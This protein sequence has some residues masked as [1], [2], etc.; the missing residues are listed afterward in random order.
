MSK[1]VLSL[2][3]ALV[4]CL[5]LLP[6]AI[7]EEA[8]NGGIPAVQSGET[9]VAEAGGTKYET[10]QEAFD[11]FEE[12][13][14]LLCSVEED[15]DVSFPA[16]VDMNGFSITG[17]VNVDG[18]LTLINGTVIGK[19]TTDTT[20][21]VMTAPDGAEAAIN[22]GLEVKS[23]GCLI[24][25]AK[26][27]VIKT[28]YVD[29]SDDVII[30]G[31][32]KAVS[33]DA[34]A[35]PSG[36][37]LY[38][39][40]TENGDTSLEAVFESD[41][42]KVGGEVA[43]KLSN[44]QVG[45]STPDPV[46][47]V[48]TIMPDSKEIYA[49]QTAE[50][51]VTYDGTDTLNAYV[52]NNAIDGTIVETLTKA[53]AANEWKF[54]VKTTE[55]AKAGT[56]R[57]Y[58]RTINNNAINA[59]AKLTINSAVAKD[60]EG[61]YYGDIK[62]AVEQAPD[63][64]TVTV[65]AK[66]NQLSLPDEIYV[67]TGSDGITLDLNGHS[68]GGYPLNVG[69]LT[70]TSKLRTGKLTV[71]DSSGGNGAVGIAVRDGG[72]FIFNPDNLS[73]NLLQLQVYGGNI[74]L[75]GGKISRD[76]LHLYKGNTLSK[77]L[78]SGK[79]L[80]YRRADADYWI[81]L[82]YTQNKDYQPSFDLVV[83]KCEHT[84]IDA[85]NNCLYCGQSLAAKSGSKYYMTLEAAVNAANKND[86]VTL[87]KSVDENLYIEKDITINLG[88]NNYTIMGNVTVRNGNTLTLAGG[89]IVN[90]VQSGTRYDGVVGG[91]LNILSDNVTVS[92]L[93]VQQI[94]NPP[95]QLNKGTF[96]KIE[97]T[98]NLE[99]KMSA[100]GLLAE[101]YAFALPDGT[102]KDGR[103]NPLISVKI[104]EHTHDMTRGECPCGFTCAHS[105]GYTN[106]E[107][108]KC[109]AKCPHTNV[110]ETTY[111]CGTCDMQMVVKIEKNGAISYGTNLSDVM[112]A[113]EGGETFT[114]LENTALNG[115]IIIA[116]NNKTVILD[117][118][119]YSV[120]ENGYGTF[121]VGG[122]TS[123]DMGRTG[124]LIIKGKGN[125]K[126]GLNI[127]SSGELDLSGWTGEEIGALSVYETA[128]VTG[129]SG[130]AHINSFWLN[131][132][133]TTDIQ[134]ILLSGGSYGKIIW[135]NYSGIDLTLGSLL[136]SGYAFQKQ[137]DGTFVS[138]SDK[139]SPDSTT[140]ISNVKVVKCNGNTDSDGDGKCDNCNRQFVAM[141]CIEHDDDGE[142][143][144][145]GF[146]DLQDAIDL[147]RDRS[148]AIIL[149][150]NVNGNYTITNDASIQMRSYSIDGTVTVSGNGIAGFYGTGEGRVNN[151]I[152]S[153]PNAKFNNGDTAVIKRLTIENGATWKTIL[154]DRFGYKKMFNATSYKW[155]DQDTITDYVGDNQSI[156]L[157][158]IARL[159]V[160]SNPTLK[161]DNARLPSNGKK[162]V[163][164]YEPLKFGVSVNGGKEYIICIQKQ[165]E[166]AITRLEAKNRPYP[167]Q[168]TYH[169][170]DAFEF[171]E[172]GTYEVWTEVSKDGYTR[173]S[174]KYTF[175]VEA[176]L[177]AA[178]VELEQS[179]FTYSGQVCTPKIKSVKIFGHDVPDTA[180]TV[181][182]SSD[183]TGTNASDN[184]S[185]RIVAAN[186]GGYTGSAI[187]KWKILPRVLTRVVACDYIK[188]YDGTTNV[189][190]D[191]I[192][193]N[194]L[195]PYFYYEGGNS[196]R[197]VLEYGTDYS[198]TDLDAKFLTPDA[199]S[200]SDVTFTVTLKN[201]NYTFKDENE[202]NTKTKTVTQGMNI[203]KA[204][205]LPT[206]C[207]PKT[208][209]VIVRN[210]AAYTYTYDVSQ[211]LSDLPD[212]LDYGTKKTFRL[213]NANILDGGYI[214]DGAV[215]ISENGILTV[216]VK[217]VNALAD[218][219]VAIVTLNVIVSNYTDFTVTVM[220]YARNKIVP[221]GNPK[222]SDKGEITYGDEIG[223]ISLS[224]SM[225]GD[226]DE[227]VEGTFVWKNPMDK[228]SRAG[229]YDAEWTF[230]PNGN[231]AHMYAP[232]TGTATIKVNKAAIPAEKITAPEKISNL[233]YKIDD[234]TPQILHTAG[235]VEDGYGTMKYTLVNPETASE[236]DWKDTPIS[237]RD[238]GDYKVYYKVFGSDN[239]KDS[240]YGTV[241]CH[242][243]KY[244]LYY[245][246]VCKARAYDGTT[247][248]E[249]ESIKFYPYSSGDEEVNLSAD[250]Y[251]VT[252]LKYNSPN[253][254]SGYGKGR[255][256]ATGDVTLKDTYATRNYKLKESG[257]I[258][259]FIIPGTFRDA[260]NIRNNYT[261]EIRYNDTTPKK[262]MP[263]D[264]GTQNNTEY[265]I[266][267][268]GLLDEGTDSELWST[269]KVYGGYP[270]VEYYLK[271]PLTK[272][273]INKKA[274]HKVRI[275]STDHNYCSD[276]Y[277]EET[278][279]VTIVIVDKATPE[280]SVNPINEVYD[281]N[282]ISA[283]KITGT[284]TYNG[285]E[286]EGTWGWKDGIAPTNTSDSG[287]YT[288]EF[289]PAENEADAYYSAEAPVNVTI[290]PCTTTPTV[291]LS[292][293]EYTYDG[294]EKKPTAAV[295]VDG[296]TLTQG[297]D[298]EISYSKN[299]NAGT[300][301][302]VTITSKGNYGFSA[303][304]K[305]FVINKAT[306]KV[307]PKDIT[308]VY[309]GDPIFALESD[310]PLI[311]EAEL[312]RAGNSAVFT[313]EGTART[314]PVTENGYVISVQLTNS[315]PGNEPDNLILTVDGT[316]ILTV[317]KASLDITVN[318][319]SREYG[320]ANPEL[321]VSYR[322]FVNG[323]DESV[324]EGVLSL[325]YED[326]DETTPVGPQLGVT[327]A[328]G[329]TAKNYKINYFP[330]NVTITKIPVYASAGTA[331]K[332]YL[333]VVFDKPLE[334]L[335]AANFVVKDSENNVVALTQVTASE[336][337]KNYRLQGSFKAKAEY[338]VSVILDGSAVGETHSMESGEFVI[339]PAR[340]S[341][342]N[343]DGGS[344]TSQTRFTVL[345][346]T[347]GGSKVTSQTVSKN[348]TVKE[349]TEA[350]TKENFDFAGWYKDK[351]LKT[352]YD[353]SEK[354]TKDITLYAAWTEKDNKGN[355]DDKDNSANQIILTIGEKAAIVFGTKKLN[356]VAP[357]AVNNRTMLPAR[358]VAENLGANVE[359]NADNNL[360]TISGKNLK[361]GEDVTI[362]ITLGTAKAQVNN[363]EITL[364]S[365][366][367]AQNNRTY[368]PV[369]FISEELGADVE[370]IAAEQK[371]VIT[372]PNN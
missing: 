143:P 79:G 169:E 130:T 225:K 159:P 251:E 59:M 33:L 77:L 353:F 219:E 139:L 128:S 119:G 300:E 153:G 132:W 131:D 321:S 371:V 260:D 258:Y 20:A 54:A 127:W 250:D 148:T 189:T 137:D 25:G 88:D 240:N 215:S 151:V 123:R 352:K 303:V 104:V 53:E 218:A 202:N 37:S 372:R 26:I 141:A 282:P 124:K 168:T 85:D 324:L 348:G 269:V 138:Y 100:N 13:I 299:I 285:I 27:G 71:K 57:L 270:G 51:T 273:Y 275:E 82:A 120:S 117:L 9:F 105:D 175:T 339:I 272:D 319:V 64:S 291:E 19:V 298:Y 63:G 304:Q 194:D 52:Q 133:K 5:S 306:V 74:E 125:I 271:N 155:Y 261:I 184:Y 266:T 296:I 180:Y 323:E 171:N 58:V 40:A 95:M 8:E 217:E 329:L 162:T 209:G 165:G 15:I 160:T 213:A 203:G 262:L 154:P 330:G 302:A 328:S 320:A 360:V 135:N 274:V 366:A 12:E 166:S 110:N 48:L 288:V 7:A 14:T 115:N 314:A 226:D 318:D 337:N 279:T 10:L 176:N 62:S 113:A 83:M 129:I 16:T 157:V 84:D 347:N 45:G 333:G 46:P 149:L 363:K 292:Q 172:T 3:L 244:E 340:T 231:N 4:F 86:T 338:R 68:L 364:D 179:E 188:N 103:T 65:I 164:V 101:G 317:E 315:E 114:L 147:P 369:R 204:H 134:S 334:G 152:M 6:A 17:N 367:F 341:S 277:G 295:T 70:V 361:T 336:D 186:G 21:F 223:K 350:P 294:T 230:T 112:N 327:K 307:K 107:C 183:T 198:I 210:G 205:G 235:S 222:L 174:K 156:N 197:I 249:F 195:L 34:K 1:R 22:G 241:N 359:W 349:P 312:E 232:T 276:P 357:I 69:G 289:T 60:S 163:S 211:L 214:D 187:A 18:D 118:N 346:E 308:K 293:T 47:T 185:L 356:D 55:G 96:Y 39:S 142:N 196:D 253:A 221:T 252:N 44:K 98:P 220:V 236:S 92:Y 67:E 72:T 42:Y 146:T 78:P 32:E 301:A 87:L 50:F 121:D 243:E 255:V 342:S 229:N 181:D 49:G 91:A 239:Y 81:S 144:W 310:S 93:S 370:W 278:I 354:V 97:L 263:T 126:A 286:I 136:A 368:T 305:F 313:S 355:K 227:V 362:L 237:A 265:V 11:N 23:G 38:G 170:C 200:H 247:N 267:S 212:G 199:E 259:G 31:T 245:K 109:G 254:G 256:Y 41:T 94:P 246:V 208:G 145:R 345:F 177:S 201:S 309:G 90:V 108:N 73:T 343:S 284:A 36:K 248:A 358:F 316:G 344:G 161:L 290:T 29:S 238:A 167:G 80:A 192:G 28:L 89:G 193:K 365:P 182:L 66:E 35:E 158:S 76:G 216:P 111:K 122:T 331:K 257:L 30:K 287:E 116:D 2:F 206:G 297:K 332:S 140:F 326:I 281:G 325:V 43:K 150:T 173:I 99:G 268:D 283:S 61:N 224:G 56:Y 322:G 351:E 228:P 190:V 264:L 280:L 24:S 178:T 335:T 234:N 191:N 233:T 106:G 102:V 207:E 311:T 75:Y 242:I